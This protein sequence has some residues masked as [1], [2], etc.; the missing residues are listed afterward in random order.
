MTNEIEN[1]TSQELDERSKVLVESGFFPD[2]QSVA[3]AKVKVWI[4]R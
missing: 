4:G 2:L 3:Q 1:Y